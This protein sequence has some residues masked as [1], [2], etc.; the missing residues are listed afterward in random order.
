MVLGKKIIERELASSKAALKAHL[1]GA[2]IHEIVV[3][4]FEREL[5]KFK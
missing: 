1:E 5:K 3:K 4:C 2:K